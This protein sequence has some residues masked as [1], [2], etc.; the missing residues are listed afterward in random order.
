[1]WFWGAKRCTSRRKCCCWPLL[2]ALL[3]GWWCPGGVQGSGHSQDVKE[4]SDEEVNDDKRGGSEKKRKEARGLVSLCF[5]QPPRLGLQETPLQDAALKASNDVILVQLP[6]LLGPSQQN[7]N[8]CVYCAALLRSDGIATTAGR[9]RS[10][11]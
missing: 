4:A 11:G 8:Q 9:R 1:M 2:Q 3:K 6:A 5:H 7:L 10:R